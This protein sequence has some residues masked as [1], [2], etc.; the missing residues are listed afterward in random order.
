MSLIQKLE[1]KS[2]N[3]STIV[4]TVK[5]D[6]NQ[7]ISLEVVFSRSSV[8]NIETI[9]AYINDLVA[10]ILVGQNPQHH[11][12]IDKTIFDIVQIH[13][14][15]E[16]LSNI[17][18][19]V[20]ALFFKCSSVQNKVPLAQYIKS[21]YSPNS[22]TGFKKVSIAYCMIQNL[23]HNSYRDISIIP[24]RFKTEIEEKKMISTIAAS[25]EN[26]LDSSNNHDG[27]PL[28]IDI[29]SIALILD[30]LE[31]SISETSYKLNSDIYSAINFNASSWLESSNKYKF[32]DSISELTPLELTS[33]YINL[34]REYPQLIIE[35][36]FALNHL[37]EWKA[38]NQQIED[39]S[40][41]SISPE[42]SRNNNL[43]E[44]AIAQ[45]CA[46][47]ISINFSQ[48]PTVSDLLEQATRASQS[49][50]KIILYNNTNMEI[51]DLDVD[52]ASAIAAD[53]I[54]I[55]YSSSQNIVNK[56]NKIYKHNREI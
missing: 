39:S 31:Q 10:S 13:K 38:L 19:M 41:L 46:S 14:L 5:L 54:K 18:F 49:N 27:E 32:T 25:L 50:W 17:S 51:E 20:S 45:N 1:A 35:S 34:Q 36:P 8:L 29:K 11:K 43:L 28:L 52:I 12:E 33:Y 42:S 53:F 15:P 23:S 47:S 16:Q 3:E 26:K 55:P 40:M 37:N 24:A 6:N 30:I 4:L 21:L 22:R 48:T 7:K 56:L 9:V 2:K 44:S